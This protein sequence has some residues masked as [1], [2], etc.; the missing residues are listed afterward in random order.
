MWTCSYDLLLSSAVFEKVRQRVVRAASISLSIAPT[1]FV[2]LLLQW[3]SSVTRLQSLLS[4]HLL[5][6]VHYN[7][8][9]WLGILNDLLLHHTRPHSW[10]TSLIATQVQVLLKLAETGLAPILFHKWQ[11]SMSSGIWIVEFILHRIIVMMAEIKEVGSWGTTSS[12][13]WKTAAG[14]EKVGCMVCVIRCILSIVMSDTTLIA[15][16][17]LALPTSLSGLLARC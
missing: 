10:L 13:C 7:L 4:H 6:R 2:L 9:L 17:M 12:G 5:F 14:A 8:L 15:L 3:L 1:G 11:V 16:S